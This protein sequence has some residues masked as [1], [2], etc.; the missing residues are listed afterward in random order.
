MTYGDHQRPKI[1]NWLKGRA[2]DPAVFDQFCTGIQLHVRKDKWT[3]QFNV[4][5]TRGGVTSVSAS[6]NTTPLTVDRIRVDSVKPERGI[7]LPLGGVDPW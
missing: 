3:V 5:N 1:Q 2:K 6:G 7:L 4:F